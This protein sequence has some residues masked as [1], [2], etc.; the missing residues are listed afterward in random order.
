MKFV[1][2]LSNIVTGYNNTPHRGLGG[3]TPNTVHNISNPQTL[4]D[5]AKWQH[6]RKL[7]NY[8]SSIS[9]PT[10]KINLSQSDILSEGTLVRLLCNESEGVFNKSYL[11]I[12]SH[13]IFVIDKVELLKLGVGYNRSN[14]LFLIG[15][16]WLRLKILTNTIKMR[17]LW[18]KIISK[19]NWL[20][21]SQNSEQNSNLFFF[22][23]NWS[24]SP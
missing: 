14:L 9:M 2:H 21:A 23:N 1:H 16:S 11:P 4:D 22:N 5:L 19:E 6:I 15:G 20:I 17:N 8:G 7:R 13:E 18:R 24:I 3:L 10:S 12:Y